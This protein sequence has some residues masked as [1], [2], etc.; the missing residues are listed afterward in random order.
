M[1]Y[2]NTSDST[3]TIRGVKFEPGEIKEVSGYI[4]HPDFK[5]I[6]DNVVSCEEPPAQS[7]KT[8]KS[9]SKN[10]DKDNKEV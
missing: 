7:K 6:K 1:F 8:A 5:F 10:S 9:E 4:H 2:K 3:K